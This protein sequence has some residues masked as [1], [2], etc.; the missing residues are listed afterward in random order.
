VRIESHRF[1]TQRA[2]SLLSEKDY[3]ENYN[4]FEKILREYN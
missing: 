2:L 1:A 3:D 4:Q